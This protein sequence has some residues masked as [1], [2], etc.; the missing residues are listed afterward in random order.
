MSENIDLVN[1][2]KAIQER[3]LRYLD[4]LA[5]LESIDM[6]AVAISRTARNLLPTGL[7]ISS[8]SPSR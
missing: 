7:R 4:K 5:A 1:E 8:I 3:V 2:G 6:R